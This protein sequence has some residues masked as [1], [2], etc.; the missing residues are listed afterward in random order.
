MSYYCSCFILLF[1]FKENIPADEASI[2]DKTYLVISPSISGEFNVKEGNH[3]N[4]SINNTSAPLATKT[5]APSATVSGSSLV[6]DVNSRDALVAPQKPAHANATAENEWNN[7]L[8]QR[9][10]EAEQPRRGL[11][12]DERET[13]LSIL[14]RSKVVTSRGNSVSEDK[15]SNEKRQEDEEEKDEQQSEPSIYYRPED[16]TSSSEDEHQEEKEGMKT[17]PE[18]APEPIDQKATPGDVRVTLSTTDT[19]TGEV[20]CPTETVDSEL[21]IATG[22]PEPELQQQEISPAKGDQ[23][24]F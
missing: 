11:D 24:V 4:S 16:D 19:H 21:P 5:S 8:K 17:I 13:L 12:N 10:E 9:D 15:R 22:S 23:N 2:E 1:L 3:P 7:E 14:H 18:E 20:I 6:D